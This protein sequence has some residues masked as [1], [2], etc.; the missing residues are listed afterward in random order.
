VVRRGEVEP[1]E[2]KQRTDE[3]LGLAEREVEHEPQRERRL[4]G[5]VGV[6]ALAA[7]PAVRRR[8]PGPDSI[9]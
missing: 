6:S 5:E 2:A 1:D 7:T 8:S 3:A 9:F 4:N